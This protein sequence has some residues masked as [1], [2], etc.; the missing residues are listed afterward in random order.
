MDSQASTGTSF[1][2]TG[3]FAHAQYDPVIFCGTLFPSAKNFHFPF[4]NAAYSAQL[5]HQRLNDDLIR[6]SI[7]FELTMLAPAEEISILLKVYTLRFFYH[8]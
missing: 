1:V 6:S 8:L 3:N 7:L 2:N 4:Q 5:L